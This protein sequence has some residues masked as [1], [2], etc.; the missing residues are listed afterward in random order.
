MKK[1][2][3]VLFALMFFPT[4]SFA[5]SLDAEGLW[6]PYIVLDYQFSF[7]TVIV[8]KPDKIPGWNLDR[9]TA[10]GGLFN[11]G[12]GV[13]HKRLRADI[14]YLARAS[15][16]GTL[17]WLATGVVSATSE[18]GVI[19]NLYYEFVSSRIFQMY[20]GG[21]LGIS[22]WEQNTAYLWEG[23]DHTY[24]RKGSSLMEGFCMGMSFTIKNH[25]SIDLG[26]NYYHTEEI[27][28]GSFGLKLGTRYTF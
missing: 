12:L 3:F 24:N 8:Q 7:G 22:N 2:A 5:L 6:R 18:E 17:S 10:W 21:G 23:S 26:F 27:D 9:A 19:C 16:N 14:T 13:K 1:L 25:F 15:V 4:A 11:I 20:L 28:M